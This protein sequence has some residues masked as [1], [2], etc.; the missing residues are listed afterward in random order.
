[1]YHAVSVQFRHRNSYYNPITVLQLFAQKHFCPLSIYDIC[2]QKQHSRRAKKEKTPTFWKMSQRQSVQLQSLKGH[3]VI[4]DIANVKPLKCAKHFYVGQA[5]ETMKVSWWRPHSGN[6][7]VILLCSLRLDQWC[8][9]LL[10][11]Q[12]TGIQ[13]EWLEAVFLHW[14][15]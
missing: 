1:M 9:I 11:M 7:R 8:H 15:L 14:L 4:S 12:P 3:S 5:E 2:I 6:N 10:F 13:F